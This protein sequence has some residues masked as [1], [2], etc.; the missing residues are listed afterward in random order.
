ERDFTVLATLYRRSS[1]LMPAQPARTTPDGPIFP[2]DSLRTF[3]FIFREPEC[4][5]TGSRKD[6]EPFTLN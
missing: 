6:S 4:I 2:S 5:L 1:Y 3:S